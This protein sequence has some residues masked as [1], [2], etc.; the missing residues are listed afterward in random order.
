MKRF[1][2]KFLVTGSF[3]L[4]PLFS[5]AQSLPADE[6]KHLLSDKEVQANFEQTIMD[7]HN[8]ILQK[9]SGKM[10]LERPGK[11]RWQTLKPSS[12]LLIADGN[13]IWLYDESLQQVTVQK[14]N[15]EKQNS[16]AMLLSGNIDELTNH[17]VI[18][19]SDKNGQQIFT[20][21]P[22]KEGLFERVDLIFADNQLVEMKLHDNLGQLS[23]V[24]FSDWQKTTKPEMFK[25]SPPPG[26]DVVP[27]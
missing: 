24:K 22:K 8:A 11:F 3:I 15:T 16:P 26:V 10:A 12:Q 17:Y 1:F 9:S 18:T 4:M 5:F 14:Q 20:L 7:S 25:F 2:L 21:R 23:D 13:K 27:A 19:S 6:L